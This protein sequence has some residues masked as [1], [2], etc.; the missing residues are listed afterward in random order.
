MLQFWQFFLYILKIQIKYYVF[1]TIKAFSIIKINT[2]FLCVTVPLITIKSIRLINYKNMKYCFDMT[3][4][5]KYS[6]N[7]PSGT[8][9]RTYFI[10]LFTKVPSCF[11]YWYVSRTECGGKYQG[12]SDSIHHLLITKYSQIERK[13]FTI[14]EGI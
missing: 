8:R 11:I 9:S 5:F 6:Y 1:S 10:E 4:F 14:C 13:I 2:S 3:F 12:N 7:P